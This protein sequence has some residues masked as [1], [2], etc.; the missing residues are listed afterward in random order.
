MP[1]RGCASEPSAPCPRHSRQLRP[2][3][4]RFRPRRVSAGPERE[5][6]RST[7]LPPTALP[8]P[9][10]A[11]GRVLPNR[12][13]RCWR[14][15]PSSHRRE[16]QGRARGDRGSARSAGRHGHDTLRSRTPAANSAP[17][18]ARLCR[19]ASDLPS[20]PSRCSAVS[21]HRRGCA[22]RRASRVQGGFRDRPRSAL[23]EPIA[24]L[25]VISRA[26]EWSSPT[27]PVAAAI[28]LGQ[29]AAS[30]RK[31][32]GHSTRP[33]PRR[34][35]RRR[36]SRTAFIR[37]FSAAIAGS[38]ARRRPSFRRPSCRRPSWRARHAAAH[39]PALGFGHRSSCR[40]SRCPHSS[41]RRS[42]HRPAGPAASGGV[43]LRL[44]R[45]SPAA[46]RGRS[47]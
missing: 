33:P 44:R 22:N 34:D 27:H 26:A 1:G 4:D 18:P 31:A 39:H 5:P 9:R 25:A 35:H 3:P 14:R 19:P 43:R 13:R 28:A 16:E 23:A 17:A 20:P 29:P 47:R 40:H 2:R 45:R 42:R 21:R 46:R 24:S 30:A 38:D 12:A 11:A 36:S 10:A 8:D 7:P 37:R 6:R 15:P 41:C 32:A